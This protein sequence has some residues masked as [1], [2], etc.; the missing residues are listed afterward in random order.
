MYNFKMFV[1]F[2]SKIRIMQ[3]FIKGFKIAMKNQ[4]Q[5]ITIKNIKGI[6]DK[7][8]NLNIIPNKPSILVAQNGFGKSSFAI[9]FDSLKQDSCIN[10]GKNHYY[11][12]DNTN[13]PYM[14][15]SLFE[16]DKKIYLEADSKKNQISSKISIFVINSRLRAKSGGSFNGRRASASIGLDKI[17]LVNTIPKTINFN[18][19]YTE[20]KSSFGLNGKILINLKSFFDNKNIVKKIFDNIVILDKAIQKTNYQKIDCFIEDTNKKN[21]SNENIKDYIENDKIEV[22]ASIKPLEEL[23][24]LLRDYE[25][26]QKR[27]DCYLVA[28]QIIRFYKKYKINYKKASEYS[29]YKLEKENYIKIFKEF[30]STWKDVKPKEKNGK[31]ILDFPKANVISNGQRDILNLIALLEQSKKKFTKKTCVL[32]I[33]EVFDYL[34]SGNLI[35]AQY[36]ISNMINKMN[37]TKYFYPLILTHLNP[38]HFKNYI[39]SKQKVYFL[40]EIKYN[41]KDSFKKLLKF[42]QIKDEP[43]KEVL[44]KYYFHFYKSSTTSQKENFKKES[45]KE[46]WADSKIFHNDMG[47][48]LGKYINDDKYCPFSVCCALR[49]K[50]EKIIFERIQSDTNKKSFL[51]IHR[52]K[53]KLNYA[54][55][56]GIEIEEIFY[57]LGIIYNDGL[58]WDDNNEKT[59][60]IITNLENQLIRN[61]IKIILKLENRS[62]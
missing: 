10:L 29:N 45:I 25:L 19:S 55:E 62:K 31:L 33:D 40:D 43:F 36:Y 50:I 28:I 12:E 4:I 24:N 9:A 5:S 57:L 48:E 26:C 44:D 11:K 54:R 37:K 22:L 49:V 2:L 53:E 38:F 7:K 13:E 41:I 60:P 46:S 17:I 6:E 30:N 3:K 27:S 42:R 21:G 32:I 16:D 1:Y 61:M 51:D 14:A 39:F 59:I 58:H 35:A 56:N 15:V 20:Q 52:T 8:F 47:K 23:K 18:Y 34:D